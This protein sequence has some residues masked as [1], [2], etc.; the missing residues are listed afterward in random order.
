MTVCIILA[1]LLLASQPVQADPHTGQSNSVAIIGSPG[2]KNGGTFPITGAAGE[3]G[4]FT[5]TNLAPNN[6]N[7]ANLAAFDTVLLN[8]ASSQMGCNMNTLSLASKNDL[9]SFINSGGKLIISDSECSPQDYSWLPYSFTTANP[10][11]YGGTGTL[12]I[13]EENILSTSNPADAHYIDNATLGGSTDAVGDMN[14]MTTYNANWCLD[15]S[16]TNYLKQTG[17]VHTYA[18][19]GTGLII[20][21]GLDM[22]YLGYYYDPVNGLRKIWLQELQA[23]S[24]EL[25]CGITV[26]GITLSPAT[27][28]NVIGDVHTVT[29]TLTDLVGAPQTGVTV[30]FEVISGP[31]VGDSGSDVTDANGMAT[32]TYTGDGGVGID[33]IQA[34]FQDQTGA[35]IDSQIVTKMWIVGGEI[36]EFPTVALPIAAILG[37]M[38]LFQ[39]RKD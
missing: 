9:V 30:N 36:P 39:R 25:T 6:V 21:N 7:A 20:Y 22:D 10:G 34:H 11:A 29:A 14:V 3:L 13:T 12:T 23:V 26:V 16:G 32:F 31:N 38:F 8:V 24:S 28:T 1:I 35:T 19:Y 17:P 5:F 4:D 2:V 33:Q 27:A 18:K 37:L 15:M